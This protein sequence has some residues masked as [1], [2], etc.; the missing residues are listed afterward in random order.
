MYVFLTCFPFSSN[1]I[2]IFFSYFAFFPLLSLSYD[3]LIY[4][5]LYFLWVFIPFGTVSHSNNGVYTAISIFFSFFFIF[6]IFSFFRICVGW[7][8]RWM[9]LLLLI[10]YN[11]FLVHSFFPL[12]FC[13]SW[14]RSIVYMWYV[15]AEHGILWPRCT[16]LPA[17]T[18]NMQ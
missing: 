6:Y 12:L 1:F 11:F 16:C 2:S 17:T 7:L 9:A 18:N 5:L 10:F 13:S 3:A 8:G 15:Y 4:L 14:Y